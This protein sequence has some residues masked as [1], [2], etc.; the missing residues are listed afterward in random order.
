MT[1]PEPINPEKK[2]KKRRRRRRRKEKV[3]A[4]T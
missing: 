4:G 2:K 3:C 1:V